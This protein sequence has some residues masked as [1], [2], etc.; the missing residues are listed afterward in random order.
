MSYALLHSAVHSSVV[1]VVSLQSSIIHAGLTALPEVQYSSMQAL[2][3]PGSVKVQV[4]SA[5]RISSRDAYKNADDLNDGK[6]TQD[7]LE[8]WLILNG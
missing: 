2:T 3:T 8:Q 1:I 7:T 5:R 4:S 6:S